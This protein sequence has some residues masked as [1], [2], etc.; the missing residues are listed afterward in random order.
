V[1]QSGGCTPVLNRSL[2]GVVNAALRSDARAGVFGARHGIEG[3]VRN[4][5]I[6]L[7][8]VSRAAWAR[9]AKS[10]AASLGTTRHS[11]TDSEIGAVLRDLRRRRIMNLIIIGGNDSAAT[12]DRIAAA[13]EASS[14]PLQV[15][16]VP[17]TIDNDLVMTDHTPGYGSAAR[18]VALAT[19]GAGLDA[20][21]MSGAAPITV[22]EVMGRDAGWLAASA[23]LVKTDER[24]APHVIGMPEVEID[25]DR[26]TGLIEDACRKYGSAVAVIA[27]N[28]RGIGGKVLGGSGKPEWVDSFGHEYHASPARYLAR[29]LA[30]RLK[31]RV[32]D[33]K[34]GT[35][36]RSFMPAVSEVDAR[37]AEE[38]GRSAVR[39]ALQG[40]SR[41]MVTLDRA[42]GPKYV[43]VTGVAPLSKVAGAVRRMPDEYIDRDRYFVTDAFIDYA[44]PLVGTRLP[45]AERLA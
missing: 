34:P 17:K 6:D 7:G 27:E 31:V 36:Q 1:L 2:Y 13:A 19:L 35:I 40:Q 16:N 20:A 11:P 9:I 21:A 12:G 44:R 45:R 24:D 39:L 8:Q 32:R 4:E 28:A 38:A 5:L 43:C 37:E 25:E 15:V 30:Q 29:M 26:F 10:P 18:F 23:A 33:E 42:P 41:V 3:L 22:I 14:F